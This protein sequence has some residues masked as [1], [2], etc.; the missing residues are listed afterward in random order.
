MPSRERYFATSLPASGSSP[1]NGWGKNIRRGGGSGEGGGEGSVADGA[2][3]FYRLRGRGRRQKK[4][5][6]RGA[7]GFVYPQKRKRN[8]KKEPKKKTKR[9]SGEV[10][11]ESGGGKGMGEV[12]GGGEKGIYRER[13]EKGELE[14]ERLPESGDKGKGGASRKL[15]GPRYSEGSEGAREGKPRKIEGEG[16]L[17]EG[18]VEN[19]EEREG[20]RPA[21]T[22]THT[23]THTHT[24]R[25]NTDYRTISRG[26][27]EER[28]QRISRSIRAEGRDGCRSGKGHRGKAKVRP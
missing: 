15:R 17:S 3:G 10:L 24:G 5:K 25:R 7:R 4:S 22:H 2:S 26:S 21:H 13:R 20:M 1:T 6:V 27:A 28:K 18:R 23:S 9:T 16:E 14:G 8:R 12:A 19:K 11:G